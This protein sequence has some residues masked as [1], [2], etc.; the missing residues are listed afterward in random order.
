MDGKAYEVST[1]LKLESLAL[2]T[3][4]YRWT[5][6]KITSSLTGRTARVWVWDGPGTGGNTAVENEHQEAHS[7]TE[8]TTV[9]DAPTHT[10]LLAR[11][12]ALKLSRPQVAA[13]A[14]VTAAQISSLETSA[15]RIKTDV[16]NAVHEALLHFEREADVASASDDKEGHASS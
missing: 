5:P 10:S 12:Q 1:L 3:M 15:K 13:K 8:N 2:P 7:M 9:A 6:E 14:G 11:R 16:L 4:E